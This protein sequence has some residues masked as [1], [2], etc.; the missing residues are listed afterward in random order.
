MKRIAIT[1]PESS[2][3]TT[4]AKTL[5]EQ[6]GVRWIPEFA[7]TYLLENN[8]N[9]EQEDLVK[10]ARGQIT[11]WNKFSKEEILICDTEML[12]MK[13]WSQVKYNTVHPFILKALSEQ[14]F[15]HYFLCRPDIP[16]EED[17]LREH[18]DQREELFEIYLEELKIRKLPFTIIEGNMDQR[19]KDCLFNIRGIQKN[20]NS[21]YQI[22]NS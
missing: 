14:Q 1:G 12:V 13:V 6:L 10:I 16:Y 17:P 2:G 4:L 15:D 7:R 22:P 18:P 19:I 3:K 5:A 8:G 21:E 9:Y 11:A 20:I